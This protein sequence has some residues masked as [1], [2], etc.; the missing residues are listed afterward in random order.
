MKKHILFLFVSL[1][2]LSGCSMSDIFSGSMPGVISPISDDGSEVIFSSSLGEYS[3]YSGLISRLV[4]VYSDSDSL[5]SAMVIN[6][7]AQLNSYTF[8]GKEYTWPEIDFKKYSLVVGAWQFHSTGFMFGRFRAMEEKN[9]TKLYIEIIR[10]E[11]L[12]CSPVIGYF[13]ILF[14]K[15]SDNPVEIITIEKN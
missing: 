8:E 7:P 13:A 5:A 3:H 12:L 4:N 10:P 14:P 15:L 9:S 2:M 6:S 11:V 1:L